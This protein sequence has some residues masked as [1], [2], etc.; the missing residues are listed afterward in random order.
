MKPSNYNMNVPYGEP[1]E[2][3][4]RN[5]VHGSLPATEA[6]TRLPPPPPLQHTEN[7]GTCVHINT[8][9]INTRTVMGMKII[10]RFQNLSKSS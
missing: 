5:T 9:L 3:L 6:L 4:L 8:N 1:V 10:N 7:N 2:T